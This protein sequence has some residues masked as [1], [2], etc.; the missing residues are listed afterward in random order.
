[1]HRRLGF[2]A[3]NMHRSVLLGSSVSIVLSLPEEFQHPPN[4][5]DVVR[6]ASTPAK[7]NL[8]LRR[9]I[10]KHTDHLPRVALESLGEMIG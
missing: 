3:R 6:V 9:G 4:P 5:P 10:T 8:K 2:L 1:V 7:G